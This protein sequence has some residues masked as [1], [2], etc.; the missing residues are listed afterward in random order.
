MGRQQAD[1]FLERM[2]RLSKLVVE[3]DARVLDE[4]DAV[5]AKSRALSL[6]AADDQGGTGVGAPYSP[7]P[8]EDAHPLPEGE[9]ALGVD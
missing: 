5:M 2:E 8:F 4:I 9:A 1:A 6:A 7:T 3:P